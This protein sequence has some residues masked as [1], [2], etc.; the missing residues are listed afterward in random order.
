[1][2]VYAELYANL[3]RFPLGERIP[4]PVAMETIIDPGNFV[5][6]IDLTRADYEAALHRCAAKNLISGV[7]HDVLHLEAALKVKA[8]VLYTANLC[9]FQRLVDAETPLELR[10]VE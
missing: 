2:H 9:D 7:I 6:T 10:S 4:S 3:T 8:A 5:K 1:M